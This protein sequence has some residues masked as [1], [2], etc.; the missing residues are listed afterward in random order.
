MK[1]LSLQDFL[2]QYE[3][4]FL[5]EVVYVGGS[6]NRVYGRTT[7]RLSNL[8]NLDKIYEVVYAIIP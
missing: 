7:R 4:G 3:K 8:P 5:E 6:I 2:E 1:Q